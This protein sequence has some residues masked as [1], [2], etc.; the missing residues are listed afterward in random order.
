MGTLGRRPGSAM[1]GRLVASRLIAVV[2]A[3][4]VVWSGSKWTV[5]LAYPATAWRTSR[6]FFSAAA[7]AMARVLR[8]VSRRVPSSARSAE[9]PS[10]WV[11]TVVA[12][13]VEGGA[14]M[15][16]HKNG[17][18]DARH[19]ADAD[20][21]DAREPDRPARD[22]GGGGEIPGREVVLDCIDRASQVE[23]VLGVAGAGEAGSGMRHVHQEQQSPGERA[24][25]EGDG[26][27]VEVRER[28][29]DYVPQMG[30]VERG[31]Q[32]ADRPEERDRQ[33]GDGDRGP[34]TIGEESGGRGP[35]RRAVRGVCFRGAGGCDGVAEEGDEGDG[36]QECGEE[37]GE[38]RRFPVAAKGPGEGVGHDLHVPS[39]ASVTSEV[40]NRR[41]RRAPRCC[42]RARLPRARRRNRP[43]RESPIP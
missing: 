4:Y 31:G 37:A 41:L 10:G 21:P 17:V 28:V 38:P 12:L 1:G 5:T 27:R 40:R 24:D 23:K 25:E 18:E 33:Q 36:Q 8:A 9:S 39:Y 6:R 43:G 15:C 26:A 11:L 2:S 34:E 30:V 3:W 42:G 29:V 13:G 22:D 14:G 20:E 32:R 35:L 19:D 7:R 16:A